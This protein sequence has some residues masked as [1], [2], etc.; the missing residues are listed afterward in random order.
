MLFYFL[1]IVPMEYEFDQIV[2]SY[3]II[4]YKFIQT[5]YNQTFYQT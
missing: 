5:Q 4:R 2:I 3:E 1:Q